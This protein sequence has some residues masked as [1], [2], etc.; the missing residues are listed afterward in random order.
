MVKDFIITQIKKEFE[1]RESFSK[2]ELF[3]FYLKYEPELKETTFRWRIFDLKEKGILG[4]VSR[5]L[6]T[7]T[8]KPVFKP[9]ISDTERRLANRIMKQFYSLRLCIWSTKILNEF[10][11]HQ[12]G[13]FITIL[14]VEKAAVEPVFHFLKDI[15]TKDVYLLP[16]EKE[17]EWYVYE[18]QSAIIVESLISKSPVQRVDQ[19]PTVTIEKMIVDIFS[20]QRLFNVY[21]GSELAN[22]IESAYDKYQCDFTKLFSYAKRRR[23]DVDLRNYLAHYTNLPQTILHD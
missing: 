20:D 7:F 13:K 16:Q 22:I 8:N 17:L 15:N 23:K 3:D 11:L 5:D 18:S 19:T 21:Q 9:V 10:M 14:E 4:P 6:L 1:N 12:P 2:K